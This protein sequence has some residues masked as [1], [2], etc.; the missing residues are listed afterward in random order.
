[1][2]IH[3]NSLFAE[4]SKNC[5]GVV[6]FFVVLWFFSPCRHPFF[7]VFGFA[8]YLSFGVLPEETDCVCEQHSKEQWM[9]FVPSAFET[10]ILLNSSRFRGHSHRS[11]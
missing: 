8:F 9:S 7:L 6:G 4:S 3:F 10:G 2:F 1:M 5:C 11:H